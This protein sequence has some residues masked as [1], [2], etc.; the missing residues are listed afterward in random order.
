MSLYLDAA[1]T[2]EHAT[3]SR[4]TDAALWTLNEHPKVFSIRHAIAL[5]SCYAHAVGEAD[6]QA[7]QLICTQRAPKIACGHITHQGTSS[8]QDKSRHAWD[9]CCV[10]IGI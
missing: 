7:A 8:G 4:D 2:D 1:F 3:L 5:G 9:R 6:A 10:G